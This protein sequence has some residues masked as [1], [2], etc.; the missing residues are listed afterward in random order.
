MTIPDSRASASGETGRPEE[1]S[2]PGS[3]AQEGSPPDGFLYDAFISYSRANLDAADKIERDLETFP[4]PR[5]IRKRLGRRHL[6]VFR[7]VN[8]L[9]GNRLDPALEHNLEQSRTLVVLCTPAARRSNYVSMEINRFAQL[10]DAAQIVPAL[11]A[12]GPNNDPGVQPA[13]WAF[14]DALGEV[15][16]SDPLA[17]DLRDAWTIKRRRAKLA[18]GSPWVQL[19]AGIIGVTTDDLTERI[20]RAERR[21]L[22]SIVAI[23]TV[24]VTVVSLL[25]LVAWDQR[26]KARHQR[27]QAIALRLTTEGE[28]MLAGVRSG[29]SVRAVQEILAAQHVASTADRGA[30]FTATGKLAQTLKIIDTRADVAGVAVSPDGRR[31]V[32]GGED[33]TV[34]LWDTDTGRPIGQPLT[35]HQGKVNSVA[36]SPDGHRIVSGGDDNTVRLWDADTGQ[37]VGQP[38]TGHQGKVNSVAFS[39]DGRRIVSGGDDNTVRLW[40]ADTGRPIGQPLTGHQHW[41]YNITGVYGVAFSPDGHRIVS[42]G[43]DTTV[44]LWDAD[45]GQPIGQPFT[46]HTN[47]VL[48]VAFSPDGTR[49][50]SGSADATVRLW[51]AAHRPT[52]R[53]AAHRP[54]EHGVQRGVQP[55][56]H[57]D[58]LRQRRHHRAP[59]GRGH[60]PIHR[61]Q[62]RRPHGHGVQRGVQPRRSPHHLGQSRRHGSA[63][64]RRHHAGRPP[65]ARVQRGVQPRRHSDR[66]RQWRHHGAAVG[67]GHRPTHRPAADRPHKLVCPA[68]RS[69]PTA[70]G[71][72]PAAGTAPCG[73]GTHTPA[74]PS[75]SH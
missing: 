46:G 19:V 21:R 38:L 61:R 51:D 7:D 14:P 33:N 63:I 43:G 23:L 36:F 67:R 31:I 8:D 71:S 57:P 68:W 55:R 3:D 44:R 72:P 17:A 28:S 16:G 74:N 20:A 11:I 59:V 35:G 53:P 12:G 15:L 60:R 9:T 73:C 62:P 40:D 34:R 42:G 25:G 70:P 13:E 22:Q 4:L 58:R 1:P 56:R 45:T 65:D 41:Q 10:R 5:D 64:R 27:D 54:R 49:I 47:A 6:N 52:H 39:P 37:P 2:G 50:V 32:S 24:I 29:G 26:N 66:L 30:L 48:S 69:A 75:A 18:R